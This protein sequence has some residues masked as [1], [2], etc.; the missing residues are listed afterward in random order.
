M[1]LEA[2]FSH[3]FKAIRH[4]LGLDRHRDHRPLWQQ[5]LR[6]DSVF[7]QALVA[8]GYL[9]QEQMLHAANRYRLGR[10]RDGGV[11]FW[12]I[13]QH[14]VE[15][16]GKVMYYRPDCH[17][18]HDHHPDWVSAI[19]RR[20]RLLPEDFETEKCLFGLHLMSPST[21]Y[22]P[23]GVAASPCEE[24]FSK[25][26]AI[27]EAEKTAVICSELF[28]QYIWLAAGGLSM[29]TVNKLLPLR[30]RKIVLFPDTDPDG[31]AFACWSRI[32]EEASS[33]LHQNI[34]VSPILEDRATPSQKARKI[35]LVDFLFV[36]QISQI[37][38]IF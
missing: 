38:Q 1:K 19:L 8:E 28:P 25:R 33:L 17:R 7:C 3:T 9:H 16:D 37:T 2:L 30:G 27:V 10:T 26:V 35:D 22:H 18:D 29:L 32:A 12:Q 23:L 20:Q 14:G 4:Q 24:P 34:Y 21:L 11:I 36:T 15:R 13:D 5:T 6:T 31:K